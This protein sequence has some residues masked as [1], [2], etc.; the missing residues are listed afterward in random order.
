MANDI[1]L[2]IALVSIANKTLFATYVDDILANNIKFIRADIPDYQNAGWLYDS[3]LAVVIEVAKG[4][5]VTWGVSSNKSNNAAYEITAANWTTFH[6]AILAAA[7]WAQDNGVYEFQI[8][9]EEDIHN[10]GT[11]LTD[12]QLRTNLR[13]TATEAKAIFTR[14]KVSYTADR[15]AIDSWVSEGKGDIDILASNVYKGSGTT[16]QTQISNLINAFGPNG[17]ILTE[18]SLSATSIET[19]STNEDTQEQ[20]I[21]EMI[22]YCKS[23]GMSR[24]TFFNYGPADNFGARKSN[25]NYRKLWNLLKITNDW[26]KRKTAGQKELKTNYDYLTASDPTKAIGHIKNLVPEKSFVSVRDTVGL[27]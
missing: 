24:I 11:T 12:A 4:A 6:D 1:E 26:K 23:V 14:G 8:G 18:F 9:N 22:K 25:G 2:G 27:D 16:W 17:T 15:S 20:M 13:A 21:E 7:Q 10:D 5:N 3:K 19:Y